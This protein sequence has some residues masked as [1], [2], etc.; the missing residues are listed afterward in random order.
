M[1]NQML[2]A[3]LIYSFL[4]R[5]QK[6]CAREVTNVSFYSRVT[7]IFFECERAIL[8]HNLFFKPILLQ[9]ATSAVL[10]RFFLINRPI[11]FDVNVFT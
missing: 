10:K 8:I 5:N 7:K 9:G 2:I 11:C 1:R 4:T 6:I 3:L